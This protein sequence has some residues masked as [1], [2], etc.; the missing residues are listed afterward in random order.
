VSG[1]LG[2]FPGRRGSGFV[3]GAGCRRT[4]TVDS[5]QVVGALDDTPASRRSTALWSADQR[6]SARASP[7]GLRGAWIRAEVEVRAGCHDP[8][9]PLGQAANRWYFRGA[10]R[11]GSI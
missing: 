1:P 3:R 5:F 4:R 2:G 8:L 10:L 6:A 11:S 7:P 9:P